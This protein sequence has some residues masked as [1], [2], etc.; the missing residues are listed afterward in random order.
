MNLSLLD[1]L[2]IAAYFALSLAVGL[3]YAGQAGRSTENFF[4]SDRSMP[5]WLATV[6]AAAALVCG[7]LVFSNLNRAQR[8]H[9]AV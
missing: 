5:W 2:I 1:W 7:A 6:F 9:A 8:R 3:Y 4:L